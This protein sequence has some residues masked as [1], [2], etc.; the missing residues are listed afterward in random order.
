MNF[1]RTQH[2]P[3]RY[4]YHASTISASAALLQWLCVNSTFIPQHFKYI[5]LWR[6]Y[7]KRSNEINVINVKIGEI[8]WRR[9]V[10]IEIHRIELQIKMLFILIEIGV[11]ASNQFKCTEYMAYFISQQLDL[12]C[13]AIVDLSFE[14]YSATC[15]CLA[16]EMKWN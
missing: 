13:I 16:S 2:Q 11:I 5:E 4:L 12:E 1:Q 3:V 10:T 8:K 15:Q 9:C 6:W 14:F 7:C